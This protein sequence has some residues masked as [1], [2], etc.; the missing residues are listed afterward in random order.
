M[1]KR[2]YKDSIIKRT[3]IIYA[4]VALLV[5]MFIL[6]MIITFGIYHKVNTT[7]AK[8]YTD[9]A[10]LY[11]DIGFF[12]Q[13]VRDLNHYASDLYRNK[14]QKSF[15]QARETVD[16]VFSN[17][18]RYDD[19]VAAAVGDVQASFEIVKKEVLIISASSEQQI[20]EDNVL[21]D[22][23]MASQQAVEAANK[24]LLKCNEAYTHEIAKAEQHMIYAT[25]SMVI[26]FLAFV[27]V[28]IIAVY[29][30]RNRVAKPIA[31]VAEWARLFD[32]DYADMADLV[33]VKADNEIAD[34]SRAFNRVKNALL[35]ANR[36]KA[37]NALA[38]QRL[39]N[40][41]EY[42]KKFVQKF[43]EEKREKDD[44]SA[45]AKRDGL[46]GLYNR[47]SFDD[48]V[49][50]FLRN[51]PSNAQGA[52]YLIDMDYF[53][54][55]NDT[56]GHIAGDEALKALSGAMSVVFPGAYLGRYGGDEFVVFMTTGNENLFRIKANELCHKMDKEFA[57][58]DKSVHIS[59]SVGVASTEGVQD[60]SE[61]YMIVDRALYYAK[62]HGRNQ[63]MMAKDL[64]D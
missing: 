4:F 40:E 58:G 22:L 32:Q 33:P 39:H 10:Q 28:A 6:N 23:L 14:A 42:H 50:E 49:E 31:E 34:L 3:I 61:L 13:D 51:R 44:I 43:H 56:L 57:F 18:Y 62:E 2:T 24:C 15:E 7:S 45:K 38:L 59:V 1:E 8:A 19:G 48:L 9:V 46:T 26:V 35:E 36:L 52:L 20:R 64:A 29:F 11:T 41:E 5:V 47:R 55:V 25:I 60:Y 16:K 37:E 27:A 21:K 63:Y 53:K 12:E 54:N 17:R 30:L